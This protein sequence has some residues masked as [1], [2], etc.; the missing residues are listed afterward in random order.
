VKLRL[1]AQEIADTFL[2]ENFRK[3]ADFINAQSILTGDFRLYD[4]T[5]TGNKTVAYPHKLSFIPMDVIQTYVTFS[6]GVG[7]TTWDVE[8]NDD[9]FLYITTTGMGA[10]DV[11]RVRALVGR[12]T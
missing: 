5:I 6:G 4:I 3:I 2:R 9:E 8:L 7:A 10:S 1:Y 11:C 12:F